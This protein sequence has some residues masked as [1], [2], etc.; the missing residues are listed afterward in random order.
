MLKKLKRKSKRVLSYIGDDYHKCLYLFLHS[1]RREQDRTY[2]DIFKGIFTGGA[3]LDAFLCHGS[4]KVV[5]VCIPDSRDCKCGL[6]DRA[7]CHETQKT[8]G[9]QGCA[10]TQRG[11]KRGRDHILIL[12][13]GKYRGSCFGLGAYGDVL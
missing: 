6:Y 1:H 13:S 5:Y 7:C 4:G 9:T 11:A 2:F 10:A 3:Y 8:S 12:R